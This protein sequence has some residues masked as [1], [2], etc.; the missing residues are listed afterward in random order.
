MQMMADVLQMPIRIHQFE[1]TCA[2]GA[3]MFAATA[4]GIYPKVE[5]AMEAMGGGFDK[6][7]SPNKQRA[8]VYVKRY[9]QYI[10]LGKFVEDQ[11]KNE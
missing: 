9:R 2:L 3:A 11:T 8:E 6:E 4:A 1:H 5:V 7:Y 10:E